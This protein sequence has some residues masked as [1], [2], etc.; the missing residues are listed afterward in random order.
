MIPPQRGAGSGHGTGR[1]HHI[2]S[3]HQ[4]PLP[5]PGTACPCVLCG[6]TPHAIPA[7]HAQRPPRQHQLQI[8]HPAAYCPPQ[9]TPPDAKAI[10]MTSRAARCR[11]AR[12]NSGLRLSARATDRC[13]TARLH[14]SLHLSGR[15]PP[16]S[17]SPAA[18]RLKLWPNPQSEHSQT[19]M[20][21]H[22][23]VSP[24]VPPSYPGP[25]DSPATLARRSRIR[26]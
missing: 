4:P 15:P 11:N 8:L 22:T 16:H 23:A 6:H 3:H 12:V 21:T 13:R 2:T 5:Q 17:C 9:T 20:Q 18:N 1:P 14:A 25:A 7:D 24:R 26:F 10:T 19:L